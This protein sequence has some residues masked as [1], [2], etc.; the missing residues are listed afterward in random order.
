LNQNG[1]GNNSDIKSLN[2]YYVLVLMMAGMVDDFKD[3]INELFRA[4][5]LP[6]SVIVI[7]IGKDS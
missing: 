1:E 3:A 2:N 7:K 5:N 4:S 6:I